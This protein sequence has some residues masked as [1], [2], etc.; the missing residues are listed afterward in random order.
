MPAAGGPT[1]Q[2]G[3]ETNAEPAVAATLWAGAVA[4]K[5]EQQSANG[6][7]DQGAV[8][9]A[10][11]MGRAVSGTTASGAGAATAQAATAGL[12]AA[13]PEA[14]T[15]PAVA[16]SVVSEAPGKEDAA[17]PAPPVVSGKEDGGLLTPARALLGSSARVAALAV[18]AEAAAKVA[19][20][21]AAAV[22]A[23]G[24][25]KTAS[26]GGRK[27]KLDASAGAEGGRR[28][29]GGV[30]GEAETGR[31]EDEEE[32]TL[33]NKPGPDA[34]VIRAVRLR[35]EQWREENTKSV[36]QVG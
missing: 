28:E 9:S 12:K 36:E 19:A 34:A 30:L 15:G 26:T 35:L 32:I 20:A 31:R 10:A 11:T 17:T 18:A 6:D 21:K 2:A 5:Q 16:V 22:T 29:T 7:V 8:P 13:P 3:P 27:V 33:E 25:S 23:A 14:H 24:A 4:K 1:E